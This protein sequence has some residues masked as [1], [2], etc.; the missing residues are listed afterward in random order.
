MPVSAGRPDVLH[1][2]RD[3]GENVFQ[4]PRSVESVS[5]AMDVVCRQLPSCVTPLKTSA[6]QSAKARSLVWGCRLAG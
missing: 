5:M 1:E 3:S 4:K 6:A 2:V